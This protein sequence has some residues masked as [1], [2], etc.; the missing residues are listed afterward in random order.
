RGGIFTRREGAVKSG[1]HE[2]DHEGDQDRHDHQDRAQFASEQVFP[3][4]VEVVHAA[5]SRSTKRPL[6]RCRTRFAYFAAAGSCVTITMVLPSS[7]LS[8]CR[9]ERISSADCRSRS[10][11]GSSHSKRFGSQTHGTRN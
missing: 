1:E 4:E 9:I 6:S 3:Y 5:S 11:V 10:P 2:E 8:S 7:P